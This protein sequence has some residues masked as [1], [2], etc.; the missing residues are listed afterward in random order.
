M[1]TASVLVLVTVVCTIFLSCSR[2][3]GIPVVFSNIEDAGWRYGDTLKF[4][5]PD[6]SGTVKVEALELAVR[7]GDDY[8]YANL[9]IELTYNAADSLCADTFNVVLADEYGKWLGS[10]TGPVVTVTDTLR[11]RRTPDSGSR[12]GVRHV[13]RTDV[14]EEI[15]QVGVKFITAND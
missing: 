9:W 10:G 8:P 4:E 15:E 6:D 2:T 5:V 7:H 11:P 14:L 12:F 1:R 3:A 13:M